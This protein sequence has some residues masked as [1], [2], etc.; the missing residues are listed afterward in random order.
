MS[1]RDYPPLMPQDGSLSTEQHQGQGWQNKY[2][3]YGHPAGERPYL[4]L[5]GDP[6][7]TTI[8]LDIIRFWIEQLG[9]SVDCRM[10]HVRL[11]DAGEY[12]DSS[13]HDRLWRGAIVTGHLRETIKPHVS[14]LARDADHLPFVDTVFRY[15]LGWPGGVITTALAFWKTL[16][17]L[18]KELDFPLWFAGVQI[19]GSGPEAFS[20]A[21]MFR[22]KKI[23]D[24]W[25]YTDDPQQGRGLA[26]LLELGGERVLPLAALGPIP[27]AAQTPLAV[28]SGSPHF[29]INTT[30]MGTDGA[31]ALPVNLDLY[32]E[33]TLVYDMVHEPRETELLRC[34]RKRGMP[35]VNGLPLL[36]EQ[37]AQAFW[38]FVLKN[39]PRKQDAELIA[40]LG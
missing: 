5:I 14:L 7:E 6:V 16:E 39:P 17:T 25:F 40:R 37:A 38:F 30:R 22:E 11:A 3:F 29:L 4:E 36:I 1:E 10:R 35:A 26:R 28:H 31:A 13:R 19:V 21:A 18:F 8:L 12:I 32:P 24:I 34:A 9:M 33:K 2:L 20:A 27:E 23:D 15:Q